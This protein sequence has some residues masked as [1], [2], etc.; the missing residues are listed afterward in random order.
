MKHIRQSTFYTLTD[1]FD[2]SRNLTPLE[3]GQFDAIFSILCTRINLDE[4]IALCKIMDRRGAFLPK[5]LQVLAKYADAMHKGWHYKY[6][7]CLPDEVLGAFIT[8]GPRKFA[9]KIL[10]KADLSNALIAKIIS[11]HP[12]EE[13]FF[14]ILTKTNFTPD[15]EFFE[16]ASDILFIYPELACLALKNQSSGTE[17]FSHLFLAMPFE[18]Q[19]KVLSSN[20]WA[21]VAPAIPS[22]G[23]Y[24]ISAVAVAKWHT[25]MAAVEAGER[26][27]AGI[28]LNNIF[29]LNI[30][31]SENLFLKENRILFYALMGETQISLTEQMLCLHLFE[32]LDIRHMTEEVKQFKQKNLAAFARIFIAAQK[33]GQS[34]QLM[35]A[36][37][38][39][40]LSNIA[41]SQLSAYE[42]SAFEV[43]QSLAG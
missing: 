22:E 4:K 8:Y 6:D 34:Y 16:K 36:N 26:S 12:N 42:N 38:L 31:N 33:D 23:P 14:D 2:R 40:K 27:E 20:I 15:F 10:S 3:K 5:T 32:E 41:V 28:A 43:P 9:K 29:S 21:A 24:H 17:I 25:F 19:S 11:A 13:L 39:S 18:Q 1:Q 35:E 30:V 7:T 37:T